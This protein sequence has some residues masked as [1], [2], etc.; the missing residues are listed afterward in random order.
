[1]IKIIVYEYFQLKKPMGFLEK[2]YLY[3]TILEKEN[4]IQSPIHMHAY[5][6]ALMGNPIFYQS[7]ALKE[8]WDF[9]LSFI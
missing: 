4:L 7:K 3:C 1:M 5:R 8:S 6:V 9:K 2:L